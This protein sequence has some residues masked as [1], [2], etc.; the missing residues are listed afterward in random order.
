MCI[1]DSNRRWAL[2]HF[3]SPTAVAIVPPCEQVL[4]QLDW[5]Q[6]FTQLA[7]DNWPRQLSLRL[8]SCKPALKAEPFFKGVVTPAFTTVLFLSVTTLDL[9]SAGRWK[10]ERFK[11][12]PN[13]ELWNYWKT[14]ILFWRYHK[15]ITPRAW[16]EQPMFRISLNSTDDGSHWSVET[17]GLSLNHRPLTTSPENSSYTREYKS[18]VYG[19][20]CSHLCLS[21]IHI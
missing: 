17:F 5:P 4:I 3:S 8:A 19:D 20:L 9:I 12:R 16:C 14:K 10:R 15:K 7:Q 1:R 6:T 11:I 2:R 18:S 13:K 21:L